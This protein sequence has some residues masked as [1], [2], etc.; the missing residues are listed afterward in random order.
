MV[1]R[2]DMKTIHEINS[3]LYFGSAGVGT[4]AEIAPW[5][6][7]IMSYNQAGLT[8]PSY[9]PPLE[10]REDAD[11]WM[12]LDERMNYKMRESALAG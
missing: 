11:I 4:A 2:M 5:Q 1:Q 9:V 3:R 7:V 12:C 6:H 10:T 8:A